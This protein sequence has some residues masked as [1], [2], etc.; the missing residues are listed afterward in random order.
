MRVFS[1]L[2]YPVVA[3]EADGPVRVDHGHLPAGLYV[4]GTGAAKVA[5]VVKR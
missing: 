5:K 4:V 3:V 2:G 1:S